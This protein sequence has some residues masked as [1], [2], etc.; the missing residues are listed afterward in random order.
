M[1]SSQPLHVRIAVGIIRRKSPW[2]SFSIQQ[3]PQRSST[4]YKPDDVA[5]PSPGWPAGGKPDAYELPRTRLPQHNIIFETAGGGRIAAV[6]YNVVG[7]VQRGS[8]MNKGDPLPH[9]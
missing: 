9:E 4:F 5:L 6:T 2:H 8:R 3:T 1:T 7:T